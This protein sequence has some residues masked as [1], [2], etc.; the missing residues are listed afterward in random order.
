[1]TLAPRFLVNF[2]IGYRIA[3]F[4]RRLS[5]LGSGIT[6]QQAA[7]AHLMARSTATAFGRAHHLTARTTYAQFQATVPPR[8]Y[9][10]FVPWVERMTQGE[11]GVLTPEKCPF[12]VETAG[13][14]GSAPKLLPVPEA[15]LRHYRNGLRDALFF[16]ARQTGHNGVFLGR[17]LHHGE[18]TALR[19]ER[20]HYR[21]SLDGILTLS[22]TP[23]AEANLR[24]PAAP[25][26]RLPASPAKDLATAKAMLNEDVTLL[27]GTPGAIH[28]LAGA[29]TKSAHPDQ[30]PPH[31]QAI[32]PNLECV[33]HTGTPLGL[34]ADRLRAALRPTVNF[35][36]VYLAAEGIIAVQDKLRMPGLRLLTDAGLFFEFL[37]FSDYHASTLAQA[38]PHCIPLE[39]VKPGI[40]YVLLL[41]TP[42]GLCRYVVG[43]I[44][45][46]VSTQPPRL[47]FIGRVHSQL[48]SCGEQV[49]ARDL[50][51]TLLA[52]CQQNGWHPVN[53]HVAPYVHRLAAGQSI[54]CHEW[55]LELRTRTVKTP[56]ANVLSPALDVELCRRN[57]HYAAKRVNQSLAAPSVRLVVP[58]LF[59][60]WAEQQK[61]AADKLPHSRSDRQ[62]ADQLAAL[63][64]FH[65]ATEPTYQ[66]ASQP[67]F[68]G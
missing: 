11:T 67:P 7:F 33:L 53:F 15:M 31:L 20:G 66:P 9:D 28:A 47:E 51:E 12:F 37:P 30:P 58:G 10:Y 21:T 13:T 32:W 16:Y 23:W 39:E 38:G 60:R 57:P 50:R 41:T 25:L 54:T 49:N 6:A 43:D 35:H 19:E 36:E 3:R 18:S 48:D 22:L 5:T 14:T 62:I 56:M 26:A 68:L 61:K 65:Q 40:D 52:V 2:W 8:H 55:W 24:A 34:Y 1:M 44:V 29:T 42:A 46:F 64:G 45:R 4:G 17:H 27:A 59:D 63:A